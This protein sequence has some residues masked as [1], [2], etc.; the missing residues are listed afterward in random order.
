[1]NEIID[2]AKYLF[3][4]KT[5]QKTTVD[6]ILEIT[7]LSKGG[8]Y[9]YFKSKEDV[10]IAIIDQLVDEVVRET[11]TIAIAPDLNALQKIKLF[12]KMNYQ[13]KLPYTSLFQSLAK[14]KDNHIVLYKYYMMVWERYIPTLVHIVQQ[15]VNEGSMKVTYPEET[16]RLLYKALTFVHEIDPELI[17][18][19][20][21]VRR[22]MFALEQMIIRTLG[23]DNELGIDLVTPEVIEAIMNIK[24][25]RKV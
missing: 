24:D 18:E 21:K 16:V 1:M 7:G 13:K 8:F 25:E 4:K 14:G 11:N 5:F 2:A 19:R 15:G 17:R 12:I 22:H 9:H 3:T 20:E 10:L 6:D 23:I